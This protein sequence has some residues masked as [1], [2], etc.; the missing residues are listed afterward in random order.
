MPGSALV[1]DVRQ[2]TPDARMNAS[3]IRIGRTGC[4]MTA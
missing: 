2:V 3:F 1:C 4:D